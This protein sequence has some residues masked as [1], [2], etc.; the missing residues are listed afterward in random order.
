MPL[1]GTT[2]DYNGKNR[3]SN[4]EE[5]NTGKEEF[6]QRHTDGDTLA[7]AIIIDKRPYFVV[8]SPNQSGDL[9]DG[10]FITL[11]ILML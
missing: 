2:S 3:K 1:E 4:S 10:V 9:D 7:E 11:Q 6:V 8:A 5:K